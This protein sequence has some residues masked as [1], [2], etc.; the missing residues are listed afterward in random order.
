MNTPAHVSLICQI[1]CKILQVQLSPETAYLINIRASRRYYTLTRQDALVLADCNKEGKLTYC[2]LE[3]CTFT[4]FDGQD[5]RVVLC[6]SCPSGKQQCDRL[7]ATS[8]SISENM[9]EFIAREQTMYCLHARS[10]LNLSCDEF[11]PHTVPNITDDEPSVDL[12]STAP[13][14]AA[15][16]NKTFGILSKQKVG[17]NIKLKCSKCQHPHCDHIMTFTEWCTEQGIA[18]EIIPQFLEVDEN[19]SHPAISQHPIPYPLPDHLRQLH[20]AIESG[21]EQFPMNL[22]PRLDD[23]TCP[24]GNR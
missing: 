16:Y 10:A 13:F 17:S 19:D 3:K 15:V 11:N 6:C 24:H 14:L 8:S 21:V 5:Q 1:G 22:V 2:L 20:D 7:S 18:E 23:S 9:D 12:L 4:S